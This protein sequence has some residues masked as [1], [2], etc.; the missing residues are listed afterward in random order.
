MCSKIVVFVSSSKEATI[1]EILITKLQCE[2][3]S[4]SLRDGLSLFSGVNL[5]LIVES[6][7]ADGV[8]VCV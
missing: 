7:M 5:E 3:C 8:C 1:T 4:L 2:H 6:K